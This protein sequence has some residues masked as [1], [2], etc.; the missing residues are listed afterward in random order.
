M[1]YS[2]GLTANWSTLLQRGLNLIDAT[3]PVACRQNIGAVSL[4]DVTAAA[5]ATG[6]ANKLTKYDTAGDLTTTNKI[7]FG[8]TTSN[9]Y[10]NDGVNGTGGVNHT[11]TGL[12]K[13]DAGGDVQVSANSLS[14]SSLSGT[15]IS[16]S[17]STTSSSRAASLTAVKV[18]YDLARRTWQQSFWF[19][20]LESLSYAV[21]TNVN[22]ALTPYMTPVGI[23]HTITMS[24]GPPIHSIRFPMAG[25]YS[26]TLNWDFVISGGNIFLTGS[27]DN[28]R[29]GS[30][31]IWDL[32]SEF[33]V[34]YPNR[35][36]TSQTI[37]LDIPTGNYNV[38]LSYSVSSGWLF[39][40]PGKL[41][42]Q[43]FLIDS[44]GNQPV[45]DS[46][47]DNPPGITY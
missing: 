18:A 26:C 24:G 29:A 32:N 39:M 41:S 5:S 46:I 10:R 45:S 30:T 40:S 22:I 27:A 16:D 35:T 13:I 6:E 23:G 44:F 25:R 19:K 36:K 42:F 43:G 15:C 14:A 28:L 4:A 7:N 8:S 37:L 31:A 20:N 34:D 3:D 38:F 1:T 12:F 21:G 11:G 33:P 9:L 2:G 17:V 47:P